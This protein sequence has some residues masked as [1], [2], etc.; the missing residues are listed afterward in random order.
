MAFTSADLDSAVDKLASLDFTDA[1][2]EAVADF[3]VRQSAADDEVTGFAQLTR[4]H[5]YLRSISGL[6]PFQAGPALKIG[7]PTTEAK[8]GPGENTTF[9]ATDDLSR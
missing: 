5:E 6:I 7:P 3:L 1:E 4:G 2:L 9:T 8:L